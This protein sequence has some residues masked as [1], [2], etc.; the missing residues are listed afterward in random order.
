[1]HKVDSDVKMSGFRCNEFSGGTGQK[2]SFQG[3]SGFFRKEKAGCIRPKWT[4]LVIRHTHAA[5]PSMYR[6]YQEIIRV[7]GNVGRLPIYR[8]RN[9]PWTGRSAKEP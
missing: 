7:I 9:S 6:E 1:M 8:N 4:E 2:C 3:E 5:S